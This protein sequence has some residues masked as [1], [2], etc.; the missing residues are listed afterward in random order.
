MGDVVIVTHSATEAAT[1]ISLRGQRHLVTGL[2]VITL[3]AVAVGMSAT[4]RATT[5]AVMCIDSNAADQ[6]ILGA[7]TLSAG[8]RICSD[9]TLGATVGL[10]VLQANKISVFPTTVFV[11]SGA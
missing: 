3:P 8:Y 7:T 5:A 9:G 2:Y 4:F 11:D 6:F 10:E 1:A